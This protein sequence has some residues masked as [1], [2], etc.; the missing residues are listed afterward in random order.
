MKNI[1]YEI[2]FFPV[3]DKT[4]IHYSELC[5]NF[6]N[7]PQYLREKNERT[8]LSNDAFPVSGLTESIALLS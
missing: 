2:I 4:Q 7:S 5:S 8:L 3:S 6:G 1:P